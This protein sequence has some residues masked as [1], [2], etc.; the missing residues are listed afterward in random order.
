MFF[1]R[2]STDLALLKTG[3]EKDC[4]A[5]LLVPTPSGTGAPLFLGRVFA[6]EAEHVQHSAALVHVLSP[7]ENIRSG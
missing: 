3:L 7:Q 6:V 2:F 4:A 5:V 1:L